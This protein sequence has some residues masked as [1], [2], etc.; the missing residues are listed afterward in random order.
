M[1]DDDYGVDNF[2]E[3]DLLMIIIH[4]GVFMYMYKW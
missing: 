4:D 2:G 3:D 1:I